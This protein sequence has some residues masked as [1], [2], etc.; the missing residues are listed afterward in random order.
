MGRS[1]QRGTELE[2]TYDRSDEAE[3]R[4]VARRRRGFLKQKSSDLVDAC[5]CP[6]RRSSADHTIH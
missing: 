6:A 5:L 3:I 1:L 2:T 4:I